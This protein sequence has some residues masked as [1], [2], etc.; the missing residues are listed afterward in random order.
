MHKRSSSSSSSL[1]PPSSSSSSSPT[2]S[3]GS[4]DRSDTWLT[5]RPSFAWNKERRNDR[6]DNVDHDQDGDDNSLSLLEVVLECVGE[7]LG[8]LDELSL[9]LLQ[10]LPGT[11]S[12][13]QL[14]RDVVHR[15]QQL[16]D[17]AGDLPGGG[18]GRGERGQSILTI[19]KDK[20]KILKTKLKL[21]L[22]TATDT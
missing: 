6:G 17:G 3:A 19:A 10:R 11:R 16:L 13:G 8:V 7:T 12:Q 18:G 20:K 22:C 4:S 1:P 9:P 21:V 15:V 5:R 14:H 2:S